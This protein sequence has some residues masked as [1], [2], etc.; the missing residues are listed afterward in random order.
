MQ[1]IFALVFIL[2]LSSCGGGTSYSQYGYEAKMRAQDN[3]MKD[4]EF[5]NYVTVQQ[6]W[7]EKLDTRKQSF[8]DILKRQYLE[9]SNELNAS[10]DYTDS[11][12]FRRKGLDAARANFDVFPEN[13]TLHWR[14]KTEQELEE[15]RT[16]RLK[17]IDALVGYSPV[18]E[19]NKAAK[20]IVSYDC[21]VQQSQFK[22][23]QYNKVN[24]KKQFQ[25]TYVQLAKISN[26]I[27]DKDIVQINNKYKW[28]EIEKP[29]PK[30]SDKPL[31]AIDTSSLKN[32]KIAK[33]TTTTTTT[34]SVASAD[35]KSMTY[36]PSQNKTAAVKAP[37][38]ATTAAVAAKPVEDKSLITDQS[39]KTPELVYIAYF[40]KKTEALTDAAKIELDKTAEQI[41]K[42][43]PKIVSIN[44]HT[45]RSYDSTA[46]L[47]TSKKRADIARDYLITKGI[48]KD[49]L[50]TYGFGKTDNIVEN[51]EG[52]EKPANNRAEITF[53]GAIN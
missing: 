36:V 17:L 25:D 49:V 47:L 48:S 12:Y 23:S 22:I 43:N 9:F 10:K 19:P 7:D 8:N 24:C 35:K 30:P 46:S 37:A 16:A 5:D 51:K 11:T 42:S 29:R 28:V 20:A 50:R 26:D 15:L 18:V 27:R 40:D 52:E 1:K 45:D 2:I 44:G 14:I 32:T 33:T 34:K 3:Y 41:K 6:S 38:T 13:P 53:K 21:W 39:D 31:Y 4:L